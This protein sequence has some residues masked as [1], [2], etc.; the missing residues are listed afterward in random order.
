MSETMDFYPFQKNMGK[1]LRSKCRQK[2]LNIKKQLL[3]KG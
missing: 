2:P 3:Q 1:N